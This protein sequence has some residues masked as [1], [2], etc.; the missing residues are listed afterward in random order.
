MKASLKSILS[1]KFI[2]GPL[3]P[4]RIWHRKYMKWETFPEKRGVQV[5]IGGIHVT[6]LPETKKNMSIR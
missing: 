6:W 4:S 1:R 5:I 3:Q 2:L